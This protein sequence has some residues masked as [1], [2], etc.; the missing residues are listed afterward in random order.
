MKLYEF[1]IDDNLNLFMSEVLSRAENIAKEE[2]EYHSQC[3]EGKSYWVIES[4]EMEGLP[5]SK[6]DSVIYKFV[7]YGDIKIVSNPINKIDEFNKRLEYLETDLKLVKKEE[8]NPRC[9]DLLNILVL[10]EVPELI[11][12]IKHI[13]ECFNGKYP[14]GTGN[15]HQ[16]AKDCYN[17]L[18]DLIY[19]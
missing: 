19:E 14:N 9:H 5:V 12:F 2:A 3:D 11:R 17:T 1:T 7:V 16:G 8:Y 13:N 4:V 10:E 15:Q 6:D 18:K